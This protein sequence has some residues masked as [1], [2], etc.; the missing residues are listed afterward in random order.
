MRKLKPLTGQ[1]LVELLPTETQTAGGIALP[2]RTLSPEEVQER[3]QNPDKPP[4]LIGIVKAIGEWPKLNNG[5]RLMPEYGLNARVVVSP[6]SGQSLQ[7]DSTRRM[8]LMDQSQ[9]LAVIS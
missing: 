5:L 6:N 4:G 8:K 1:V 3:H 2:N 7:W 9:V